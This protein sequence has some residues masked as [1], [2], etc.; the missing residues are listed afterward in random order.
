MLWQVLNNRI[1]SAFS[2]AAMQYEVLAGLQRAIGRELVHQVLDQGDY[3]SI[4][5]VGMGTGRL[6][7]RLKM[8]FPQA[9]V[10]GIDFAPGMI[11]QARAKYDSFHMV[12]ADAARLP[13]KLGRFDLIIS[14]LVYQWLDNLEE[15][16]KLN[17][18]ILGDMGQCVFTLFGERTLQ[19]LFVSL[20]WAWRQG[21]G[22]TSIGQALP[23]GRL[24]SYERVMAAVQQAGFA[25]VQARRELITTHFPDMMALVKWVKETGANGI[26]K[27][28]FVGRDCLAAA[29]AY[30]QKHYQDRWG[31]YASFE[32]LWFRA[33]KKMEKTI[34]TETQIYSA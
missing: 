25:E 27:D 16:F 19:E 32:I 13:F 12:M 14:N 29:S 17:Y 33:F 18:S 26:K 24:P 6:T 20:E 34:G 7:N 11:D 2:N 8:L 1:R 21:A 15:A 31:V 5:D 28:F 10:V 22:A 3:G 30:Y 4:L 9:L 23:V